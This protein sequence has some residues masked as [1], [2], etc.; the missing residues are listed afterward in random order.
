M[1][2]AV[3]TSIR[4]HA[5]AEVVWDYACDPKNWTASNPEEHFGLAFKNAENRPAEGVEFHQRESVAGI[6]ADLYGRFHYMDRPHLAV[7]SGTATYRKLAGLVKARL[8]E[9]GVLRLVEKGDGLELSHNVYIDF[10]DS[11]WGRILLWFF[12]RAQGRRAVFNHTHKELVFF[13]KQLEGNA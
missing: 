7:W 5:P 4:I 12:D 6:Y 10:P 2:V 3:N 13:K 9:G 8:P 1:F 11:A